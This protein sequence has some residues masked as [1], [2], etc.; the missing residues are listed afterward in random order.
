MSLAQA[1]VEAL[2]L[3]LDPTGSQLSFPSRGLSYAL[4]ICLLLFKRTGPRAIV[5]RMVDRNHTGAKTLRNLLY[6]SCPTVLIDTSEIPLSLLFDAQ[7]TEVR[8]PTKQ[9]RKINHDNTKYP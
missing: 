5:A 4:P 9:R 6:V 8:N 3:V 1:C 7:S 2:L